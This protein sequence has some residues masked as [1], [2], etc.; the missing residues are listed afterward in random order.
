MNYIDTVFWL[1]LEILDIL[2]SRANKILII[3]FSNSYKQFQRLKCF[4]NFCLHKGK[5]LVNL[6]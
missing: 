5:A 3:N 4:P 2:N 6:V 1:R